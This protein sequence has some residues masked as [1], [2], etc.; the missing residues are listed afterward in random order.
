LPPR[1]LRIGS[2]LMF[3]MFLVPSLIATWY[4]LAVPLW[5]LATSHQWQQTECEVL[6]SNTQTSRGTDGKT[7][8]PTLEITYRYEYAGRIHVVDDIDFFG[9]F[10]VR[11][12]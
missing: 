2:F 10:A 7:T 8:S 5:G 12:P 9:G 11:R 1:G 3:L 6:Q 4:V